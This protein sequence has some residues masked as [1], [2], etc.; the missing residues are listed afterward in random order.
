[1]T[2]VAGF[3]LLSM[4]LFLPLVGAALLLFMPKD[5]S[6]AI[7]WIANLFALAGFLVSV[8][9]WFWY[10]AQDPS[11]QFVERHAVDSV[12]GRAVL[13][14]RRRLQRAAGAAGDALRLHRHS[15]VV[16]GDYRA[17]EGVLHLPAHP[18]DRHG[19]RVR[20]PRLPAVL[21]VLGSDA[22]ADVFPHRHL[23][24][25]PP[26]VL[27]DQVLPVHPGRQRHHAARHSGALL[28]QP[29]RHRRV[30]VRHHAVPEPERAVQS[31]V[32]GVP[33]VL[34]RVRG[35]GADV[36][37]PHV[38]ARRA[39]RCAD[40]RLGDSGGCPAEDGHLRIHPLLAADSSRCHEG[41]SCR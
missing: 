28:L 25:R 22:R 34:P 17:R 9:L 27:G 36:P 19:G 30:H 31:A 2:N 3:P 23:G 5:N 7:R 6:N 37:V 29:Q 20:Q 18:A 21:P 33:R 12:G 14:R 8:P 15:L 35:E 11:Y 40:G 32:V 39:Y 10:N 4:I 41:T 38:A 1:M 13:P 16:D 26:A 24:K